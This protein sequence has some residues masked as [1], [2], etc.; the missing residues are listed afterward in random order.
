MA[1]TIREAAVR[2]LKEAGEP[3]HVKELPSTLSQKDSG[4]LWEKHR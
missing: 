1:M 3:L 4:S 2:V